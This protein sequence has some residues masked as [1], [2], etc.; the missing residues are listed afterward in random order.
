MR[1]DHHIHFLPALAQLEL[2]HEGCFGEIGSVADVEAS[3]DA[4]VGR[5]DRLAVVMVHSAWVVS[6]LM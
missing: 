6:G 4:R 2:A 3:E 1:W 5:M